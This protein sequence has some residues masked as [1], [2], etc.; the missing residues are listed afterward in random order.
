[1][2]NTFL[3]GILGEKIIVWNQPQNS[4]AVEEA[5]NLEAPL[6]QLLASLNAAAYILSAMAEASSHSASSAP[7]A[8]EQLSQ[9]AQ[10]FPPWWP[11]PRVASMGPHQ[12]D[13]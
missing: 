5:S 12:Q 11:P 8:R 7:F 4:D 10:A 3:Y 13:P 1:M 9:V 6:V 2:Y